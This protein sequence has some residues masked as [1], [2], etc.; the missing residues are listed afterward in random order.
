[1]N[2]IGIGSS[3]FVPLAVA[4]CLACPAPA[5]LII[6]GTQS[7]ASS[8]PGRS[9]N[10]VR[11]SVDLSVSQGLATMTF[12]NVSAAAETA[13]ISE[14]VVDTYDNDNVTTGLATLW[15]PQI[16]MHTSGVSFSWGW[17][18]GLPGYGPQTQD[19]TP[20]VELTADLS[21]VDNGIGPGGS[22]QVRFGTI[23][24]DGSTIFD[25][26]NSFGGGTDTGAF[27]IGFHAISAA[28]VDGGSLS[29]TVFWTDSLPP[30]VPEPASLGLLALGSLA[31]LRRRARGP[32]L[33]PAKRSSAK[34]ATGGLRSRWRRS[35]RWRRGS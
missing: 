11:L 34:Q 31:I 24:P 26:L 6:Y 4:A 1:M 8:L 23:L 13:V 9:L 10:D 2:R 5:D 15:N 28:A 20:L 16:L 7:D 19:P 12:T 25:Y 3:L 17:S 35:R 14:I 21:P 18:N 30:P 27:S 33:R 32:A 29:G 22:L